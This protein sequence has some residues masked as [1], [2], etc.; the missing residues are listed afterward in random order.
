[1]STTDRVRVLHPP[2]LPASLHRDAIVKAWAVVAGE[3][4]TPP[5]RTRPRPR[6]LALGDRRPT[7]DKRCPADFVWFVAQARRRHQPGTICVASATTCESDRSCHRPS[8]YPSRRING[9]VRSRGDTRRMLLQPAYAAGTRILHLTHTSLIV[10]SLCG[11]EVGF[12]G[13]PDLAVICD[14]CIAIAVV[15]GADASSWLPD[16]VRESVLPLAA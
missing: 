14:E 7:T 8:E 12:H 9:I 15:A 3:Q 13:E 10:E 6:S 1:M 5:I 11:E 4:R 2:M 16:I